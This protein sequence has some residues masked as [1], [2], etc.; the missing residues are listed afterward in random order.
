MERGMGVDGLR[1]QSVVNALVYGF[2]LNLYFW[3]LELFCIKDTQLGI[4]FLGF[5]FVNVFI[6][7]VIT[8]SFLRC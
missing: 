6:T 7:I 3:A 1:L 8:G 4:C 2:F 5:V